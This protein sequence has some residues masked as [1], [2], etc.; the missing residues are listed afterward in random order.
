MKKSQI[1]NGDGQTFSR[2]VTFPRNAN[3]SFPFFEDSVETTAQVEVSDRC[4]ICFS[5]NIL[6]ISDT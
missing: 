4:K 1:G 5:G 6:I 2:L 3:P